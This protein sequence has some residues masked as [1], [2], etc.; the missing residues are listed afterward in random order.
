[1]G[2]KILPEKGGG[3]FALKHYRSRSTF[4]LGIAI[5]VLGA[6]F[7]AFALAPLLPGGVPTFPLEHGGVG[8]FFNIPELLLGAIT[9]VIGSSVWK[10][11]Y[12]HK[13]IFSTSA[14]IAVF[15][16]SVIAAFSSINS[17]MYFTGIN[18]TIKYGTNDLGYFGPTEQTFPVTN[19]SSAN[20]NLTVE[21]DGTIFVIAFTLRESSQASADDGIASINATIL[22][23]TGSQATLLRIASVSPSLPI[24]FAPDSL[25]VIKLFL[26]TPT[27]N[28]GQDCLPQYCPHGDS[29]GYYGPIDFDHNN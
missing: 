7:A 28:A 18:V 8:G 21:S 19:Q 2:E 9:I 15:F 6:I 11:G 16:L 27:F 13:V 17:Y 29:E 26:V 3:H 5:I 22:G 12:R 10:F 24:S 14:V 23:F 25:I 4:I 20:R 1:L